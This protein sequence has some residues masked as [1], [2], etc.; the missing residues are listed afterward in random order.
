MIRQYYETSTCSGIPSFY[1]AVQSSNCK[2]SNCL[3]S[4]GSYS[5]VSCLTGTPTPPSDLILLSQWFSSGSCSGNPSIIYGYS[6]SCMYA[7][8]GYGYANCSNDSGF[9]FQAC[10]NPNCQ[11]CTPQNYSTSCQNINNIG[12]LLQCPTSSSSSSNLSKIIAIAVVI[13]VFC[14][15][16]IAAI[17]FFVIRSQRKR[18]R[19]EE[20]QLKDL[21]LSQDTKSSEGT[22]ATETAQKMNGSIMEQHLLK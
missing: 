4:E 10:N 7:E 9:V 20:I 13:P 16:V 2:A 19:R 22:N 15:A 3:G 5:T 14:I 18:K 17:I 21:Q 12:N 11:P 6:T 1:Y 8:D